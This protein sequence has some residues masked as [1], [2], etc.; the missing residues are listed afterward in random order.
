M[1]AKYNF[2]V[3]EVVHA[4]IRPGVTSPRTLHHRGLGEFVVAGRT[5]RLPSSMK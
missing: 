4:W 2:F 5:L 3:L 1:V